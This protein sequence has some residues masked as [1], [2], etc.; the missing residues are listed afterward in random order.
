M[1]DDL[2]KAEKKKMFVIESIRYEDFEV[3][4]DFFE[5]GGERIDTRQ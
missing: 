5:D 1:I 3:D 4:L 2:S